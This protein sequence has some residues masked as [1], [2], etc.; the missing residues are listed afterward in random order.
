ML[1]SPLLTNKTF[2]MKYLAC[3]FFC[4]FSL[5]AHPTRYELHLEDNSSLVYYIESPKTKFSYPLVMVIEG[6]YVQ[7]RGPQSVLRLHERFAQSILQIDCGIITL[8]RRGADGDNVDTTRFHLYNTPF[9]RLA[10]HF[11]LERHLRATPPENWNG[12]LVIIGGSEGG[13]I[14]IKLAHVINPTACIAIVGCGDQSFKDYIWSVIQSMAV[15]GMPIEN[16]LPSDRIAYDALCEMMKA[17]P[18]PNQW[19]F[20][21]TFLYWAGT[22]DQTEDREFLGLKCPALVVAG[23]EDIECSSTD[24]LIARARQNNQDITYLRIEGM[25]HNALDPE[26]KVMDKIQE[27]ILKFTP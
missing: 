27:F 10:D 26:W 6:S 2:L 23:S 7:E 9:Q 12:Q 3:L 8:E 13:P 25:G 18:D 21:Q 5:F 16:E 14:A 19:W 24:R 17:N 11:R 15:S 4:T 1:E 20:G 22:L